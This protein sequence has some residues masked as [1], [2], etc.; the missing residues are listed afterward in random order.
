MS[1]HLRCGDQFVKTSADSTT[2]ASLAGLDVGVLSSDYVEQLYALY[3]DDAS[4]VPSEWQS[5]FRSLQNG[6]VAHRKQRPRGRTIARREPPGG[7]RRCRQW[8]RL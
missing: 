6:P 7:R 5:Y 4:Q 1:F 8:P 2:A 3:Q